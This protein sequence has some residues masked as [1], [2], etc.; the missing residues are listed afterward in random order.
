MLVCTF[1][2]DQELVSSWKTLFVACRLS[3]FA[4]MPLLQT[5]KTSG[6]KFVCDRLLKTALIDDDNRA[7]VLC[8]VNAVSVKA[9]PNPTETLLDEMAVSAGYTRA[10]THQALKGL[11]SRGEKKFIILI[12]DE[13]DALVSHF[14]ATNVHLTKA[15]K[16]L[17]TILDCAAD[18]SYPLAVI[19]IS[20][21]IG[22]T[23]LDRL[24]SI[25]KVRVHYTSLCLF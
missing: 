18:E 21:I 20:N 3:W 1:A 14:K 2:V 25:G 24:H 10:K 11:L 17:K 9:S 6:V 7:P 22:N 4:Y 13:V 16:A 8:Y 15:E 12:M 23:S 19:G 5:G